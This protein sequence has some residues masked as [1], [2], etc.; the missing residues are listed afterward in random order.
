[1][2]PIILYSSI[3]ENRVREVYLRL[4]KTTSGNH[5]NQ[6]SATMGTMGHNLISLLIIST[7][8]VYVRSK[9]IW[10]TTRLNYAPYYAG[11]SEF[12]SI[13]EHSSL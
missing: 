13:D 8:M 6:N 4:N 10:Y 7:Y 9:P 11:F 2:L 5:M 3:R 12:G 1:M